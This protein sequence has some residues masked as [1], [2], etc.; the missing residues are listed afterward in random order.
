VE[1]ALEVNNRKNS[2]KPT[3]LLA[4]DHAIVVA[5]LCHLLQPEFEMLGTVGDGWA[6]LNAA[7]KLNPDVIVADISMPLLNGIEAIRRLKKVCPRTKVVC[8]SMH[9]EVA[10]A[11]EALNAGASAYVLKHSAAESLSEAIWKVLEGG[12]FISPRIARDVTGAVLESSHRKNGVS[13]RLTQ[14]E[15]EV[16][17]LVAEGRTDQRHFFYFASGR[18]HRRVSQIQYH[19]QTRASNHGRPDSIRDPER[20]YIDLYTWL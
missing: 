9:G 13:L 10:I 11:A 19:G 17:Q 4:D 7:A 12:I 20:T 5:G 1:G 2:E 6:L 14:R 16:L 18:S 15:R 3:L 8:L